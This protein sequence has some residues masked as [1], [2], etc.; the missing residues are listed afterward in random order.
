MNNINNNLGPHSWKRQD[1]IVEE[2][3]GHVSC[4]FYY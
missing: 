2:I 3:S 1:L 4:P